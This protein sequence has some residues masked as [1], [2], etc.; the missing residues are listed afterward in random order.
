MADNINQN[1]AILSLMARLEDNSKEISTQAKKMIGKIEKNAGTVEFGAD[2]K[3]IQDAIEKINNL[4][5]GKLKGID[6]TKQFSSILKVFSN[7]ES[8]TEDYLNILDKVH[9]ELSSISKLPKNSLDLMGNF[10]PKQVEQVLKI[11][12]KLLNKQEQYHKK[13]EEYRKKAQSIEAMSLVSLKRRYSDNSSYINSGTEGAV[14]L[15][16]K[17]IGLENNTSAKK[18]I[19]EYSQLLTIFN[20]LQ[21]KK[22]ELANT[23][24]A[25]DALEE[26]EINKTLLQIINQ[27]D[28]KEK[29]LASAFGAKDLL[30][31][32]L[33]NFDTGQIEYSI[34]RSI[35]EY[36]T[37]ASKVVKNTIT[38]LQNELDQTI[39][40]YSQKNVDKIVSAQ[41]KA[42]EK[43]KA[44][45][46]KRTSSTP[47]TKVDVQDENSIIEN[48]ETSVK[49][50]IEG[51]EQLDAALNNIGNDSENKELDLWTQSAENLKEEFADII[52][53]AVNAETALEKVISL[54]K[55]L[56]NRVLSDDEVKD[57]VGYS[58]R[59][60]ALGK[61]LSEDQEDT[62]YD[63]ADDYKNMTV[64][65]QNMTEV[66]LSEIE[67]LK[68]AQKEVVEQPISDST[69]ASS[70]IE[71]QVEETTEAV[72][73]LVQA[74][75]EAGEQANKLE[76][77]F[78]NV[79]V[80][81]EDIKKLTTL[82]ED[83][84]AKSQLKVDVDIKEALVNTETIQEK[85]DKLPEVKDIKIRVHD[86]DYSNTSLLSD[87]EGKT[88]TAF[89][90]VKN[91]WSGLVNDKGIAFFTDQLE[92][93]AD[94]ADSLA[95]SGKIYSAN[96]SFKNPLEIDGNGAVWNE[97]E[98]D[99]IKRTTDEIVE[100]AK[101]LGYDGV[102]FRNIRDGFGEANGE[103]SNVM[104]TL[105]EAQ[106]KNEQVVAAV[107]AGTGE[108]TKIL[109]SGSEPN[110]NIETQQK[111]QTELEQTEQQAKETATALSDINQSSVLSNQTPLS[112]VEESSPIKDTF[113]TGSESS[114]MDKVTTAT[115]EAV[116]AKKDFATA[117]EGV[118][119]SV[120]GSKSKL[121]LEAE[122]M[123]SIAKN[124]H[125]AAKAKKDFVKANKD[126]KD[127]A[128]T[129]SNSL[130]DETNSIEENIQASKENK[131]AKKE[132]S[133][134]KVTNPSKEGYIPK[135][136][137]V[138]DVNQAYNEA[139]LENEQYDIKKTT[140][141]YDKLTKKLNEYYKLKN[142]QV[143]GDLGNNK[144]LKEVERL[145]E[146][147]SEINDATL[148]QGKFANATGEAAKAQEN[149]NKKL[150]EYAELFGQN[151]LKDVNTELKKAEGAT[152]KTPAYSKRIDE[153]RETI[154]KLN[155]P[156]NF[157]NDAEI[158]NLKNAQV[159]IKGMI[160]SLKGDEF[161]SASEELDEL[162]KKVSKKLKTDTAAPKELREQLEALNERIQQFRNSTDGI[163]KIELDELREE[164][165]RLD[166]Q[167]EATGKTGASMG[168][169]IKKKFK[170]VAAYFATYVS[171]YDALQIIRQ[172]FE[173]IK[174]YDTALT[175][176]NKVSEESIQTLKEFQKESFGLADSIG[177]TAQQ[178]QASTADFMRLG[179][180][181]E[182]A[183][184]SAQDANILFN[185]SEFG[186]IN[187]ATESLVSMSQAYREL[188]KGEIIDVV[189]NLGN[190]FA[191]STDGLATALQNSASALKTAQNDFFEAAA[192]TTAANT[193]VQDPDKVGAGLRTIALRLTG[194]EAARE[195]LAALGED[196]D[197]FVVTTTSKMDQQIKDLTKTQ[198]NF[199]VSLLD[200]N[201]NYRSTYEVL[202]DIAKVWDKIAEEDLVTGENRQNALLEMMAGKNRSNILASV[203][204]SPEVLEEA[205]AYA[206]DSEGSAM[207]ENEAYLESIEAHLSQLKNAWDAL[208]INENNREVITFFLDLAK[209]VLEVVNNFGVLNTLLVGGGGIFAA[210]KAF[211][212][213][214]RLK[215][216]SLIFM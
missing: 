157:T 87:E 140:E 133:K 42:S 15:L 51:V 203:L 28:T 2:T 73:K 154:N 34:L 107:K 179:E 54:N 93:A 62:F 168:D 125:E 149:F 171:I 104:V 129:S 166:A 16:S 165:K 58:Q 19:K 25:K 27:I 128:N 26:V 49:E 206:L 80:N 105:N 160:D 75:K 139:V 202:L 130:K 101:Q 36:S 78:S 138:V 8:S 113:D 68:A 5:D 17:Q 174:E 196:V 120:D 163:N 194:T 81:E 76:K 44:R 127:S 47:S 209:S 61:D 13:Q 110:A 72:E 216:S 70:V 96:L 208:W 6:L 33:E 167:I 103:L 186:S 204:Q 164:F 124:A 132:Q 123:E 197:D 212:K 29:R 117:N 23:N 150:R 172:G 30:S 136:T 66:Q 115:D 214:G 65:I 40:D 82:V 67:K 121:Q 53:Y 86:T 159:R 94:Y 182:D 141:A 126:V 88:I 119:D 63:Y 4:I 201:G 211:K 64:Q 200:M 35:D 148:G 158:E 145:A 195:E 79:F 20:L 151:F 57:L 24:T 11:Y 60:L 162:S 100:L 99:G 3:E 14:E 37:R 45:I 205:Y 152:G 56:N 178:I 207:R 147:E 50:T 77:D 175:E 69:T 39:L 137:Y 192:L 71:K 48:V 180:S 10:S 173:I 135:D 188:E 43:V 189:N 153:I 9:N 122:L 134:P 89:R 22:K 32:S 199:G 116:Q 21:D 155:L 187:E 156:I 92:L 90:G 184:R 31:S 118:Q 38:Q 170:D 190:N 131:Q 146:L 114:E 112:L 169:K 97:I 41:E 193:V 177:T 83:F 7:A 198:G 144:N 215:K 191:I 12:D 59:Y 106:I 74:E 181:L 95:N 210:I 98:F 55:A 176:M 161:K 1:V 102:I 52:K 111:L 183:K 142:K 108:I 46:E 91:A 213:D 84:N 18:D 143:K 109:N 85:I 185:V